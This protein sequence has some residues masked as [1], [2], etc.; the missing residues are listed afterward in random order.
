MK[1]IKKFES[2]ISEEEKTILQNQKDE[3][4]YIKRRY[5]NV[6]KYI[7]FKDKK[8]NI[9]TGK[10][11][12][13]E[14]DRVESVYDHTNLF[15]VTKKLYTYDLNKDE[16]KSNK[17]QD[18]HHTLRIDNLSYI[19]TESDDLQELLSYLP[20]LKHANKYNL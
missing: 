20:A 2:K 7:L 14:K 15:I 11:F 8:N 4:N 18:Y 12:I 3:D 17:R 19:M 1:Y 6:K 10:Y 13:L 16:L 5:K 9:D